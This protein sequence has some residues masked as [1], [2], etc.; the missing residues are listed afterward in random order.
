MENVGLLNVRT[1]QTPVE[2]VCPVALGGLCTKPTPC[3]PF[4]HKTLQVDQGSSSCSGN[5]SDAG[6][7]WEGRR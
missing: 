7:D 1:F 2:A 4:S 5:L 6:D 3:D